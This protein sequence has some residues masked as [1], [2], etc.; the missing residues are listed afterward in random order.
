MLLG[1]LIPQPRYDFVRRDR[2]EG[3]NDAACRVAQLHRL[4]PGLDLEKV[5]SGIVI[6]VMG[7]GAPR[8]TQL[9]FAER[10]DQRAKGSPG[11]RRDDLQI[12]G[13]RNRHVPGGID[14]FKPDDPAVGVKVEDHT[15]P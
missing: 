6:V 1:D 15:G 13:R 7:S 4:F 8:N 2:S 10:I 11:G 14:Y 3:A 9:G 5:T 12:D